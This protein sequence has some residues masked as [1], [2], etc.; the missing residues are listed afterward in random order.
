MKKGV[1]LVIVFLLATT[2]VASTL[3]ITV[4]AA[5]TDWWPMFRHDPTHTG[6]S[7][8]TG[9]TTNSVLWTYTTGAGVLSSPTVVDGF[10]Y[11]GSN[12]NKVYCL[13]A[14]TGAFRWSFT[15]DNDAIL[16]LPSLT[17]EST[18]ATANMA[19]MEMYTA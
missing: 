2:I 1:C 8:S 9:P 7:T 15:T 13:N 6:T 4:K 12:D 19:A 10:V 14:A 11:A 3:T 18:W 5:I 17:E 16:P